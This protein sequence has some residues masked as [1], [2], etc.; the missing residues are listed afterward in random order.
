MKALSSSFQILKYYRNIPFGYFVEKDFK[1]GRN[2]EI[3]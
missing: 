3:L 1:T 2:P